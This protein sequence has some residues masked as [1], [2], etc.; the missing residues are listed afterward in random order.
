MLPRSRR[1]TNSTTASGDFISFFSFEAVKVWVCAFIS[2]FIWKFCFSFLLFCCLFSRPYHS[3]PVL[4][5][6]ITRCVFQSR[7]PSV[8]YYRPFSF[9]CLFLPLCFCC[10]CFRFALCFYSVLCCFWFVLFFLVFILLCSLPFVGK[11]CD[12][13]DKVRLL[14]SYRCLLQRKEKGNTLKI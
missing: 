10:C 7:P 4:Y 6:L 2:C 11:F 5:Q 14:L 3:S 8:C 9:L 13:T 12:F 1:E